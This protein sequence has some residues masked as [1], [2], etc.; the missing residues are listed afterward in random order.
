M[1][2]FRKKTF[3]NDVREED[4]RMIYTGGVYRAVRKDGKP[5]AVR[6]LA[7]GLLPAA[8]LVI[9]SGFLDTAGASDA[10]YVILPYIA[11][12]CA[13]FALAWNVIKLLMEEKGQVR[14]FVLE[15]VQGRIPGAE[16]LL[17]L[18]ALI[19]CGM[20][21]VYLFRNGLEGGAA[22]SIAYPVLKGLTAAA[23]VLYGRVFRSIEFVPADPAGSK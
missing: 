15:A 7:A 2:F 12:V 19:G 17:A 3:L 16:K 13:L 10:F 9:L 18:F 4:G 22:Q 20:S 14:A 11:E 23:A 21:L 5:G 6:L 8:A 1:A